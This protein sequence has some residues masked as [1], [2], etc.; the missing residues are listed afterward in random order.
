MDLYHK[1]YIRFLL[2]LLI[3]SPQNQEVPLALRTE[4]RGVS[5]Q[6][7]ALL[8][9]PERQA[10]KQQNRGGV[11]QVLALK[12]H[13]IFQTSEHPLQSVTNEV[14]QRSRVECTVFD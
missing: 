7:E 8:S 9:S 3:P 6:A 11:D 5:L 10:S 12:E 4:C 1:G 13:S 14:D 2:G